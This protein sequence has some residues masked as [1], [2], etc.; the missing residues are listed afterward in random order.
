M[1]RRHFSRLG[2]GLLL[3][4]SNDHAWD[5]TAANRTGKAITVISGADHGWQTANWRE[6]LEVLEHLTAEVEQ[7]A[8][9]L[10]CSQTAA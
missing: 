5:D 8:A 10:S 9:R 4:G 6:E 3:A 1:C 2:A 7:F